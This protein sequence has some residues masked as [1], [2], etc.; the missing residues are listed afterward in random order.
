[1][2]SA[3]V[4]AAPMKIAI[5]IVI[6]LALA[7]AA[8]VLVLYIA[9][10]PPAPLGVPEPGAVLSGVTV[11]NPGHGREANRLVRVEGETIASA[12]GTTGEYSGAFV[13]P[14]LI[15]MHTHFPPPS[16]LGNTEH[17]ALLFLYHGVTTVRHAGDL[18]GTTTEPARQGVRS[19]AFP[20]PRAGP[21]SMETG[22]RGRTRGRFANPRRRAR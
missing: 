15:D 2:V 16:A 7:V 1:M 3:T 5:R 22:P 9:L 12:G 14:G 17:F 19:G 4:Y 13:L 21:S 20:G 11:I 8:L 6:G 18:D 10:V